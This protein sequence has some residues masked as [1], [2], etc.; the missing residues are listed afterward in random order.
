M[1]VV[2][3][4]CK[5]LTVDLLPFSGITIVRRDVVQF[6]STFGVLPLELGMFEKIST[7]RALHMFWHLLGFLRGKTIGHAHVTRHRTRSRIESERCCL[8]LEVGEVRQLIL[9]VHETILAKLFHIGVKH[10][11][12]LRVCNG[13]ETLWI[14]KHLL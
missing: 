11:V 4:F 9:G 8:V 12:W 7:L 10:V 3:E 6:E 13:H 14:A 2:V 5:W 1:R